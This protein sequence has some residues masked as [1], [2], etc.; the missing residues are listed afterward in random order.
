MKTCLKC[1][2]CKPTLDFGKHTRQADGLRN[3]CKLCENASARAR[4]ENPATKANQKVSQASY[5]A[6]EKGKLARKAHDEQ[7]RKSDKRIAYK[8][9]YDKKYLAER[10]KSD[11]LFSL[12]A[13]VRKLINIGLKKQG[14]SRFSKSANLVGCDYAFL[15]NYLESIFQ[16][17]MTWDNF[18]EWHIDH[19]EPISSAIDLAGFAKRTHYTNLQPM[20]GKYNLIKSNMAPAEWALYIKKHNI[21]VSVRPNS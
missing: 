15:Q 2:A 11:F 17:E 12:A 19:I 21:D 18:G 7:Y 9:E 3:W 4:A 10:M 20:W 16:P 8:R 6:S 13:K 14:F 5:R 1:K